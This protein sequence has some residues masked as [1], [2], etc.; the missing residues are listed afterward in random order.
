MEGQNGALEPPTL[1][2]LID[3]MI[4]VLDTETP[5]IVAGRVLMKTIQER[6]QSANCCIPVNMVTG[7]A[8][9]FSLIIDLNDADIRTRMLSLLC[10]VGGEQPGVH[11]PTTWQVAQL[12]PEKPASSFNPPVPKNVE[13]NRAPKKPDLAWSDVVASNVPKSQSCQKEPA[14]FA[15]FRTTSCYY[16]DNGF[17]KFGDKCNFAH[18]SD[19]LRTLPP[20]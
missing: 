11:Y 15:A 5:N 6:L 13:Q 10:F 20:Q 16:F 17:C 3:G 4:S 1:H 8:T 18:G 14:P 2:E 9:C 7:F 19:Q 12:Y